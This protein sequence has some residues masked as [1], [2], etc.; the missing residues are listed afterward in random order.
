MCLG[1]CPTGL[2]AETPGH[3]WLML[4]LLFLLLLS[5]LLFLVLFMYLKLST[6]N[7]TRAMFICRFQPR[8][9]VNCLQTSCTCT[10]VPVHILRAVCT[11]HCRVTAKWYA[12]QVPAHL[13][14]PCQSWTPL[15]PSWTPPTWQH[16]SEQSPHGSGFVEEHQHLWTELC[17][18]ATLF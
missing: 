14:K 12:P 17:R 2:C 15:T 6:L 13:A 8:L 3:A 18:R 7:A 4:L 9:L 1:H 10:P 16:H 5:S 11:C